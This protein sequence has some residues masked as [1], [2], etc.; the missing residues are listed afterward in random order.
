MSRAGDVPLDEPLAYFLTWPTYGTWLPGDERGW[1]K[2]HHGIQ[3]PDPVKQ[4]EARA[5]M[6]EDSCRLNRE[7]RDQVEAAIAECC[8]VRGWTLHAVNCRTNHVHVVI[9]AR[10][11]PD[12]VRSQLKTWSAR[13]LKELT[14]VVVAQSEYTCDIRTKWWADRGSKKYLND[15]DQL[16]RA[17][18]YV[19]VAQDR[20]R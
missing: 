10:E 6:T 3:P 1:V 20:P 18:A 8:A 19:Q 5:R 15:D 2:W 4:L 17:V 16:E 11:H 7:E 9:S 13:K 12:R 14:R